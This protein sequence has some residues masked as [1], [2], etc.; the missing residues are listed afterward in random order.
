MQT[1]RYLENVKYLEGR[2]VAIQGGREAKL[3]P[4]EAPLLVLW[5]GDDLAFVV[6]LVVLV[7]AVPSLPPHQHSV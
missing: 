7:F 6:L 5:L 1:L 3:V 2:K 4:R